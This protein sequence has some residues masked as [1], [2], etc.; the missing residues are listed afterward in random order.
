MP[1][2]T[3]RSKPMTEQSHS[4]GP[5]IDVDKDDTLILILGETGAGKST[6]VN[7]AVGATVAEVGHTLR[8]KTTSVSHFFASRRGRRFIF[9]DT[10]GFGNR[11]LTDIEILAR[12]V[13]WLRKSSS[14]DEAFDH[15]PNRD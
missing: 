2:S 12:I 5:L 8:S 11:N 15:L 14:E 4:N 9:V 3:T 13:S 7:H 6:F 1:S 10:P